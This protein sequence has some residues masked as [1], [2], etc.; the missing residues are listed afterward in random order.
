MANTTYIDAF[1][2]EGISREV[3]ET[4][5]VCLQKCPVMKMEQEESRVEIFRLLN[6]QKTERVLDECT[7]CFNCNGYCPQGL[8]PY[9]LIMERAAEK[10]QTSGRGFPTYVDYLMT[11]K[12]DSCVFW[13]VYDG[14]SEGEKTILDKWHYIP[15]RSQEVL[16]IGCMGREIPYGTEHSRVFE[17]LPKYAPRNACCGELAY[18][19]GDY[20]GFVET[21]ERTRKM[22]ECLDT[23]RLVCYCGSCANFLGNIWPN[24]HGVTLPFEIVSVWEWLWEKYRNGEIKVERPIERK[25]VLSDSCYGSELGDGFLDAV[26]GLHR[27][28]GMEVVELENNR[29]DN[30]TCGMASIIRNHYDLGEGFKESQRKMGQVLNTEVGDLSCYC[31]GCYIQLQGAAGM[32]KIKTHYALEEILWAFGDE[33]PVSLRERAAKQ[34]E[35]FIK[36]VKDF[37]K[38]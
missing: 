19:F 2:P 5:G 28:V 6:G 15:P 7:F 33:Y 26:R 21:V 1:D 23:K 38:G 8:R 17:A 22:L 12:T 4:C 13:D 32:S 34:T 18:R 31:P 29:F 30:L 14:E 16:F 9:A 25:V 10:I 20:Q 27:A 3:C 11:G 24:Y 35:L 37:F 36:K